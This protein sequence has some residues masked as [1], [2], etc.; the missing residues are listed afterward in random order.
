[1]VILLALPSAAPRSFQLC[2]DPE[3]RAW[4]VEGR[5]QASGEIVSRIYKLPER[6][7]LSLVIRGF[8]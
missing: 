1:M 5:Q 2:T 3:G 4:P 8:C 6:P 7:K